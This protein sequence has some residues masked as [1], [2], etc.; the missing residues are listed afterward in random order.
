M[1]GSHFPVTREAKGKLSHANIITGPFNLRKRNLYLY[2]VGGYLCHML[3][4]AL[5]YIGLAVHM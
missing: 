4:P 3:C 5:I 1:D 2:T